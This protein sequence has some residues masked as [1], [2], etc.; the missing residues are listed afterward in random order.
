MGIFDGPEK[1]ENLRILLKISRRYGIKDRDMYLLEDV[2]KNVCMF[3]KR[4][5]YDLER[6]IV[7]IFY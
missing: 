7:N 6:I 4:S 1:K 2:I 5:K 3:P